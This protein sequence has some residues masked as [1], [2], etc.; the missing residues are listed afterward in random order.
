MIDG[1]RNSEGFYIDTNLEKEV[2]S[3][4]QERKYIPE[5]F[6]EIM[7]EDMENLS[8]TRKNFKVPNTK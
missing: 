5:P 3:V 1:D 6:K 7:R 2:L 4:E 8:S